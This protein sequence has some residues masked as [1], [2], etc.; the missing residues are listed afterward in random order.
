MLLAK[1]A[2]IVVLASTALLASGQEPTPKAGQRASGG[3]PPASCHVTLLDG[4]FAP[5]LS[6]S[7]HRVLSSGGACLSSRFRTYTAK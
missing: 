7:G 4:K 5:K 2:T 6:T 3:K 1:R